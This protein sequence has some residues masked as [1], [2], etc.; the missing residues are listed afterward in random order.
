MPF[1]VSGL[2]SNHLTLIN[3]GGNFL[4]LT[5][6]DNLVQAIL[7]ALDKEEAIGK[8]YNITDGSKVTSKRFI[9]DIIS[10]LGIDYK[11][12][13]G[14]Y[15]LIYGVAS[16]TELY[17][18]LVRRKSR[19]PFTRYMARFLRYDSFFDVSRAMTEL[20]YQPKISYGE[21][22]TLITPYL[23]SLYYGRK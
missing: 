12:R 5:N 22:I 18:W 17:Y 21:G 2:K 14:P 6:V 3:D 16:L 1:I 19:P 15:P 23:R 10:V 11:L 8:I 13:N 20:D 9:S 7:I 4:S